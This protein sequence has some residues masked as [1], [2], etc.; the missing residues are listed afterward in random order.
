MASHQ[1]L[2]KHF[3]QKTDFITGIDRCD[4]L[5]SVELC[6]NVSKPSK[7]KHKKSVKMQ[8]VNI[9]HINIRKYFDQC[10]CLS[11]T[12]IN[13]KLCGFDGKLSNSIYIYFI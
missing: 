11:S 6:H 7:L 3:F 1:K 4:H 8:F 10:F 5:T 2:I 12:L 9:K 13:M